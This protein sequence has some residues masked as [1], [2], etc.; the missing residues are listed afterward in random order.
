MA[1]SR[2]HLHGY[3]CVSVAPTAGVATKLTV[4][5]LPVRLAA[6]WRDRRRSSQ[7]GAG[8]WTVR[9][10]GQTKLTAV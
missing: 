5:K 2:A 6:R 1:G 7:A 4:G 10:P 8:T 3:S 9:T